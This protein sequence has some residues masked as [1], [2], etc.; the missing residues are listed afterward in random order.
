MSRREEERAAFLAA[1][2]GEAYLRAHSNLPGPR[3]NLEL[4]DVAG[5]A[6]A[7]VDLQRWAALDPGVAPGDSPAGFVVC[8]GVAGLGRLV[9]AGDRSLLRTLRGHANDP[10][11]RVR[12]AVAMGL[13]YWGDANVMAMVT[14]VERWVGGTPLEGRAAMA[15]LCEPRLLHDRAVVAR[16]LAVLG[17]LTVSVRD[18]ADG[19]AE[20][21]RVLRQALGYG[22][23]VAIAADPPSGLAAFAPW[24]DDP[25]PDVRWIVRQN[26]AKSRLT[27]AAPQWVAEVKRRVG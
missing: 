10:R 26:L 7:P 21:V 16:V 13:Q 19:H 3:G 22:W 1:P 5:E 15:A 2:D 12:E 27:R 8:V 18:A 11:W 23:S 9:A 20:D 25:N 4:L 24:L 6:A 17:R 14:E